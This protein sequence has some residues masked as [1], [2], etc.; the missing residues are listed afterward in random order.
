MGAPG[1]G[2]HPERP[3]PYRPQA[4]LAASYVHPPGSKRRDVGAREGTVTSGP[5]AAP[6]PVT[7]APRESAAPR[8]Q[9]PASRDSDLAHYLYRNDH[10]R[11][12]SQPR[13]SSLMSP[14]IWYVRRLGVRP[15]VTRARDLL[16][17]ARFVVGL[18]RSAARVRPRDM[19]YSRAAPVGRVI[20]LLYGARADVRRLGPSAEFHGVPTISSGSPALSDTATLVYGRA[21]ASSAG[22][23]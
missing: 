19:R 6:P 18:R 16:L 14:G 17:R 15:T 2:F 11:G 22:R 5:P 7:P 10:R 4:R 13:R 20:Q 9:S 3:R 12:D 23:L 8:P 21:R 1:P